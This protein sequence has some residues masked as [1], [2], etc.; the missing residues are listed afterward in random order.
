MK[1]AKLI[2]SNPN[3]GRTTFIG[4]PYAP[5]PPVGDHESCRGDMVI[6]FGNALKA[7]PKG[8]DIVGYIELTN[9]C[10][11][12]IRKNYPE[13]SLWYKPHPADTSEI[14]KLNL[15]GFHIV[16]ESTTSEVYL[17]EHYNDIRCVFAVNSTSCHTAYLMGLNAFLF[18][19]IFK[20]VFLDSFI[21]TIE[22]REVGSESIL[23]EDILHAPVQNRITRNVRD[24]LT[25]IL[26]GI[27]AEHMGDVWMV[28]HGPQFSLPVAGISRLVKGIDP[29]R[30]VILLVIRHH[31]LVQLGINNVLTP[32]I[33]AD[34][35]EMQFFPRL[36]F[37]LRPWHILKYFTA[38]VSIRRCRI[39][40]RD[41]LISFAH[42]DFVEDCLVSY[43]NPYKVA[44]LEDLTYRTAYELKANP[45]FQDK[46]FRFTLGSRV[47]YYIVCPILGLA[48][49][50]FLQY[51]DGQSFNI[52]RYERPVEDL[53]DRV[54]VM[55]V[56]PDVGITSNDEASI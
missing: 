36:F 43:H 3:T 34:V 45:L 14:E 48:R 42:A 47:F 2:K 24:K 8:T 29:N 30:R 7:F 18:I 49:I 19:R 35:D 23:L 25:G 53:Y 5:K 9:R 56:R 1:L 4:Y 39:P 54:L 31:R 52:T 20:N 27:L 33:L 40:S 15:G 26:T 32:S 37:R 6:F 17:D 21:A 13:C 12:Y 41:V 28:I 50:L 16:K 46:D 38:A 11:D 22:D 44:V 51:G 55:N 10:L